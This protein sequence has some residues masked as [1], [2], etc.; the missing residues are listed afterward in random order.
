[1][2]NCVWNRKIPAEAL[3]VSENYLILFKGALTLRNIADK[4]HTCVYLEQG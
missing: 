4:R 2:L 3:S 1:M